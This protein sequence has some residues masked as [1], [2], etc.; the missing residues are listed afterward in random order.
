[1]IQG[2]KILVTG[3][4]GFI[5]SHLVEA[6]LK[7]N[8]QVICLDNLSTGHRENIASYAQSTNFTFIEGDIRDSQTCLEVT[9][10]VDYVFH[11]AALGSVPRS[12]KD[13]ITT[14]EVNVSGFVNILNAAKEAKVK[15]FVYASSSSVYGDEPTLPKTEEKIGEPLS[16]YAVS[17]CVNELYAANFA[18]V[19]GLEV[20]G[21]RYFNVFGPRQDPNGPYA[22]VIPKFIQAILTN[23][24]V[25][26][27][28]DG[29]H[30]RDFTYVK[31]VVQANLMAASAN[32]TKAVNQV[33]NVA[34]GGQ[35]SLTELVDKIKANMNQAKLPAAGVQVV[36]GPER[37]GDIKHSHARIEKAKSL[38]NYH[39][40]Y[41]FI[42]G[43]KETVA[44]LC[45]PPEASS[46]TM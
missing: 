7:R 2:K 12:I 43:L 18:K 8:N 19:Y 6:L 28:G 39:P 24:P 35:I 23:E 3:G 15:R 22:A 4:A 36:F 46:K 11:Q 27:N 10:G 29:T 9:H 13:P 25:T 42:D 1:M 5:G 20:I 44:L 41:S 37:E 21:L 34:C 30:S 40:D 45:E 16:P 33:Y 31:N 14:N 26:I 32:N 38:L 17:K